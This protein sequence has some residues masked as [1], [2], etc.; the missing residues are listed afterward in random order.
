[1]SAALPPGWPA[2]VPP[3]HAGDFTDR[4]VEWLLDIVPAGYRTHD[5][6]RRWPP[7]LATLAHHHVRA[8]VDG[9]RQGYRTVRTEL[10]EAL[11]PRAIEDVLD[12]YRTEGGHHSARAD[13]V[14]MVARALF[15]ARRVHPAT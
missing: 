13:Q 11:P 6:F 8:V 12:V 4:A 2:E 3:P 5:I 1:M 10:A 15:Y 14:D 7:A 9:H